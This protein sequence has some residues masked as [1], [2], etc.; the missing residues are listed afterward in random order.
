[1]T[2]LAVHPDAGKGIFATGSHD[3]TI[4]IANL[5]KARAAAGTPRTCS[6]AHP[7]TDCVQAAMPAGAGR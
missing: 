6:G 5:K 4:T 1:V 7:L 3:C 2:C